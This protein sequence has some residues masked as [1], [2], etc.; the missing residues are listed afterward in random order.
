LYFFKTEPPKILDKE[1]IKNNILYSNLFDKTWIFDQ[2]ISVELVKKINNNSTKLKDLPC[3]ISRGSSTGNDK[4]FILTRKNDQF[5]NG[6]GEH[7]EVE[8]DILIKPIF[9]TNFS[10]YV[11]KDDLD[12][13]LIFPYILKSQ[14]YSLIDEN[15]LKNKYP[16]TYGYLI[17]QK[18]KLQER[19]Q[20]KD[21]YAYS[22]AR[23]LINHAT[24]DILIPVFADKGI[25][26][27]TPKDCNYTLMAGGGFSISI[28]NKSIDKKFLLCLLNSKL[29][30]FVLYRESNKFRGGYITCTKQ[31][32]ENLPIKLIPPSAQKKFVKLVDKI[33]SAKKGDRHADTSKLEKAIDDLVYQ[34]YGLTEEEIKIVEGER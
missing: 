14:N 4:I 15:L 13:Y 22:A 10:R 26:T 28:K 7:I 19:K 8:E 33:L 27:L 31:Y 30:F 20:V 34:L 1:Y 17:E 5:I 32:F 21:W 2:S 12:T 9:A 16:K 6:F 3:D 18:T 11:F 24:S 29:L 25:F 23:N